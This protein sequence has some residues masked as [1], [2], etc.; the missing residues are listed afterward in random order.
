MTINCKG[1]LIDLATPK[2]MGILNITPNSFY[3]GGKFQ[4]ESVVLNQV[5]KMLNEGATFIDIG[6]YSSK[7]NA[8]FVSE[9]EELQRILPVLQQII[10]QFPEVVISIDTF[11]AEVAKQCVLNGAAL[12]NDIS[13]G[14]LDEKMLPT[15]A[16]LQVPYI[17]MHMKGNPQT[18]QSMAQYENIVKEMLF[19]FS[20]KVAQ[21]R[22]F[23]INDL[24]I[25]PGFGFAKT[26][27]Q[28]FEVMNKLEL[29]Q[30]LELPLLVGISRKSLIYKTLGIE[31]ADS[32][33]GTSVLNTLALEKG[34]NILRVHDVK[35][36]VETVTLWSKINGNYP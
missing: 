12:I 36:A 9:E 30:M 23:G 26:L 16:E 19:Y 25:D 11:R 13:A 29:F 4:E 21:A 6:A 7:P 34:A 35:E 8:A 32:L 33:N 15:I 14:L 5:E 18:M 31:A 17:M 22:S 2:V 10:K 28:N 20:E 3:D 1:N 27:E 24:I